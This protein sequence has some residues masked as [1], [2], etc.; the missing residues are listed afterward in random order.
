M[1][2]YLLD[3]HEP[4]I[5]I[6]I[7]TDH[8]PHSL[9]RLL[10]SL[11]SAIYFGDIVNV[12]INLEQTAGRETLQIVN[13]FEWRFGV[14][15]VYHRV[16]H[17]GLLPAVTESWYPHTNNSYGIILEDDTEVSPLFYAWAKMA[18]LRYR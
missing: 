17:G 9:A 4:K 13:D 2:D 16:V 7:V 14:L 6:S 1:T 8:R 3:W 18:L 11:E 12:R 5:E 10:R 15:V